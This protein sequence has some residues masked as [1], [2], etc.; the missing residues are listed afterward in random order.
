ML[1]D[2][3]QAPVLAVLSRE[4]AV[5]MGA[6]RPPIAAGI[7]LDG[8]GVV[9]VVRTAGI[10][11]AIAAAAPGL[12]VEEVEHAGPP[13]SAR[14]RAAG[15]AEATVLLAGVRALAETGPAA[16]QTGPAARQRSGRAT[17]AVSAPAGGRAEATVTVGP[18]GHATC[19][20]IVVD[21]GDPLDV[22]TLR[23]YV[24]G[25]AHMALGWVTTE[26]IAVDAGGQPED[27]TIRSWGILRA[28]DMPPVSVTVAGGAGRPPCAVSDTVFAAVAAATWIALGLPPS[29]PTSRGAP[30]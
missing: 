19:V 4:D 18:D 25:A 29:W 1:A 24:T 23:S 2:R 13:T 28:R 12:V 3:H 5:R 21:A 26:G 17:A 8:T 30:R 9:R 7:R 27:L 22:V 6:K 10:A 15:W 11:A 14:V 20:E 16:H